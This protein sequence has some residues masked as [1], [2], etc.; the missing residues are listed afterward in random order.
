MAAE[1]LSTLDA[2]KAFLAASGQPATD[3][4]LLRDMI[5]AASRQIYSF[6]TIPSFRSRVYNETYD[7][8]GGDRL[9]LR[10]YPV[11][12]I[13]SLN[14]GASVILPTSWPVAGFPQAGY[15]LD[16]WDGRPPAN[17]QS[18][19]LFGGSVFWRGKGNIRVS[20]TAGF[21]AASEPATVP[22]SGPVSVAAT[23]GPW[24][25]DAGV[26]RASGAGP[27]T[28]VASNPSAGQ[29]ALRPDLPGDYLFAA[30]DSGLPI[31][32]SYSYTPADIEM[33]CRGIVAELY[34]YT[35]R[36]GELS[37]S[38]GGQTTVSYKLTNLPDHIKLALNPYERVVPL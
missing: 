3:D 24:V 18:V 33:A 2:V 14:V 28:L 15:I 13:A 22:A 37:K 35:R 11:T 8:L 7:G 20:Y 4:Q 25:E 16:V 17:L 26:V 23:W 6:C 9:L 27:L 34:R 12:S 31:L 36:I 1:D 32:I 30:A 10:Q 19:T 5:R 21:L 38:T 29:Y